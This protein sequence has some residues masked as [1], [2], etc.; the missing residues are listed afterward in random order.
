VGEKRG[1]GYQGLPADQRPPGGTGRPGH[2]DHRSWIPSSQD[3]EDKDGGTRKG[4]A[5][6]VLPERG[7]PDLYARGVIRLRT[8]DATKV[9]PVPSST[10][11][12][13]SGTA[14]GGV[15]TMELE[16]LPSPLAETVAV[17]TLV[18]E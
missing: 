8:L 18:S 15:A 13:G 11:V 4:P 10:R 2:A 3:S 6:E 5:I 14:V 1:A 16:K 7:G 9:R 17:T 12:A